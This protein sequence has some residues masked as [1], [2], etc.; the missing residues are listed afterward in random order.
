MSDNS[1]KRLVSN[2]IRTP[3]GTIL[4]SYHV[5]D[6]REYVDANGETYM[7]DGGTYYAKRK[8]NIEPYEELSVYEDAPFGLIRENLEWGTYGKLG[9]QQLTWIKLCDMETEHIMNCL[10]YSNLDEIYHEFFWEEIK[11][12]KGGK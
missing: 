5:H 12:R 7:V 2:K 6:Y 8:V 1:Y 9:D 10:N 4:K 3:D 11:Y